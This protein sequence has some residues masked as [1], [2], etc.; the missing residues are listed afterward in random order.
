[1]NIS[2]NWMMG[3]WLAEDTTLHY[4]AIIRLHGYY[5]CFMEGYSIYIGTAYLRYTAAGQ[6]IIIMVQNTSII[7]LPLPAS[8]V[9]EE[10]DDR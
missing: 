8:I 6:K 10:D 3:K 5:R 7:M 2:K 4:G 9:L 1:M